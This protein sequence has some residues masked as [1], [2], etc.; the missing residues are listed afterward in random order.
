LS[1]SSRPNLE[2]ARPDGVLDAH[3]VRVKSNDELAGRLSVCVV[4]GDDVATL[5]LMAEN[6][7]SSG[8]VRELLRHRGTVVGRR[9][10]DDDYLWPYALLTRA[11]S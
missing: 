4:E 7:D 2:A 9:V 1:V 10:V 6:R 5:L 3:I 11:R 8:A